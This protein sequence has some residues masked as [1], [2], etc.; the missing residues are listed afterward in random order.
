MS[1]G[2]ILVEKDTCI[3]I[4]TIHSPGNKNALSVG[5]ADELF[6]ALERTSREEDVRV[7]VLTGSGA[8]FCAGG[9]IKEMAEAE[10]KPQHLGLLAEG[11]QRCSLKIRTMPQPVI[12]AVDGPATGAG[13]SLALA[14]DMLIASQGSFFSSGFI[15]LGLAPGSGTYFL[16][17]L[18]GYQRACE[19][20]FGGEKIGAENFME[21]G[22]VNRVV[23]GPSLPEALVLARRLAEK[24]SSALA[25]SKKILN[26][27]YLAGLEEHFALERKAISSTAATPRFMES[28]RRFLEK[29]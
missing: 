7:V 21:W 18:V 4:V 29:K 27:A 19:I 9:D 24:S 20:V 12:G 5:L 14:C 22:I 2:S 11:V 8:C 28:C 3:A 26:H 17:R 6:R 16:S 25:E 13:L 15:N 1:A 10:N 23:G